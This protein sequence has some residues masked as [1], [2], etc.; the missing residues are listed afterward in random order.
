MFCREDLDGR[1]EDRAGLPGKKGSCERDTKSLRTSTAQVSTRLNNFFVSFRYV[2][3]G[4]PVMED[5]I[6]QVLEMNLADARELADHARTSKDEYLKR[7][8]AED[9]AKWETR[10]TE[11]KANQ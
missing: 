5:S 8:A 10:L 6:L 4:G 2:L 1:S 11:Y 3:K 9:L 7:R